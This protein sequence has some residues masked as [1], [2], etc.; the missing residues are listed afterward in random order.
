VETPIIDM[1]LQGSALLKNAMMRRAMQLV[2]HNPKLSPN[3]AKELAAA[4]LAKHYFDEA[5]KL[6][7]EVTRLINE[8]VEEHQLYDKY[9]Q[10]MERREEESFQSVMIDLSGTRTLLQDMDWT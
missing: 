3:R 2:S 10:H 6:D 9:D 8:G 1:Y 4:S 5:G 7:D